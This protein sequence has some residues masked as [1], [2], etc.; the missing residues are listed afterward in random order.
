MLAA[1]LLFVC[2]APLYR[3][4]WDWDRQELEKVRENQRENLNHLT[5][6]YP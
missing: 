4:D 6:S 3:I 1:S 2:R 5:F